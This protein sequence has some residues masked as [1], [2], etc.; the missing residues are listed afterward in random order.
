MAVYRIV[1]HRSVAGHQPGDTVSDTE[2][3][4][5]NVPALIAAGHLAPAKAPKAASA[6]ADEADP[7]EE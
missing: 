7:P 6:K 4:G 2:L 5:S 1:G 3:A